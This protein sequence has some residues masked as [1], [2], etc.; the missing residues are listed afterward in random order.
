MKKNYYI[1][2][3]IYYPSANLHI[4]HAYCTTCV[5]VIARVRRIQGYNTYFL[6][7]A[8]EHG[9]KIEK[10]AALK[11]M[12]PQAFVD[13]IVKGIKDLW[14]ALEIT[15]DD[16]IRTTE[17]RHWMVVQKIFSRLLEQGDIYLGKYEGWYCTPCESFWTDTQV[18]ENHICP[19]CGREVHKASEEAYFFKVSKYADRLVKFYEDHP[20]FIYPESRKN[21]MLNTFIKPGLEDLCISRTSFTWGVPIKENPRHIIYVWIDALVNYISALGYLSDD[22]S[23]FETFWGEDSE[24]VHVIGN[25]ITRF[26]TIYW[27]ILLMALGLRLPDKVFVHGLLMM[28]DGKMSKSRGNVVN[29]YPLIEKYGVDAVRY[30][31]V[32]ETIFG[33][34][35]TF[36]PEQFAERI[37]TDLANSYGN[38]LS[39]TISMISKYF[40]GV[41]PEYKGNITEF[42]HFILEQANDTVIRYEKAFDTLKITDAFIAVMDLVNRANKYI[43]ETMPWAL[44]KDESKKEE[45]ASVMSHLANVLYVSSILLQP[46]LIHSAPKALE[47]LGVS[48]ELKDYKNVKEFGKLGNTKVTKIDPLFPR[49]DVAKEAEYIKGL[50][51]NNK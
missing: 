5:D 10:N 9:E 4:G 37:N 8:D 11:G 43:D 26:H 40:D 6:T 17:E 46:V 1:T 34:D 14:K 35:G 3:P 50:M 42:D 36:S 28:K 19:D 44:A 29:P 21:E 38:L 27:P 25:D 33:Q 13:D 20:D 45:L 15:N 12:T 22:A 30:Y 41:I 24:I 18:G 16:F 31:L 2:T 51:Q 47:A 49:L 32:R 7:G 39:R 23:K 48:E